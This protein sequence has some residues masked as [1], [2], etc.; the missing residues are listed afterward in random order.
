[1]TRPSWD[2]YFAHLASVVATRSTCTRRQ[3]GAVAVDPVTHRVLGTGFNGAPP[4]EPHCIDGAC[5][6]GLLTHDELPRDAPYEGAGKCIADHAEVNAVLGDGGIRRPFAL[7]V[8]HAPC[9]QCAA[10]L[11]SNPWCVAVHYPHR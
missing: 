5:P 2:E 8:T 11:A 7:H 10:F 6:R 4:G 3:V 9:S 1:M